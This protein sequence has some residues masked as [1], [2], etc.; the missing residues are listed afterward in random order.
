MYEIL[1]IANMT[2]IAQAPD[3]FNPRTNRMEG[4]KTYVYKDTKTGKYY[5]SDSVPKSLKNSKSLQLIDISNLPP[6]QKKKIHTDL[7]YAASRVSF[8]PDMK[9]I[10]SQPNAGSTVA[11]KY[12]PNVFNNQRDFNERLHQTNLNATSAR[13]I[14]NNQHRFKL[15]DQSVKRYEQIIERA[16]KLNQSAYG[17]SGNYGGAQKYY[18]NLSKGIG[19]QSGEERGGTTVPLRHG[20]HD[21]SKKF[22]WSPHYGR[23]VLSDHK[24]VFNA[25]S[26]NYDVPSY[27]NAVK[28]SI[29][30]GLLK[31]DTQLYRYY[32]FN[33]PSDRIKD[34]PSVTTKAI[35]ATSDVKKTLAPMKPITPVSKYDTAKKNILPGK[36]FDPISSVGNTIQEA[37]VAAPKFLRDATSSAFKGVKSMIG[38]GI[39]NTVGAWPGSNIT[40]GKD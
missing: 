16:E 39:K 19:L 10:Y 18:S 5:N 34:P 12:D 22:R 35:D 27:S 14:L 8:V 21:P 40:F 13:Y 7:S 28:N 17:N 31:P 37:A 26:Q 23:G 3:G 30:P 32:G 9:K 2:K 15:N 1:A 11:P 24:D 20:M 36:D 25:I 4:G 38:S 29:E 33:K 6:D